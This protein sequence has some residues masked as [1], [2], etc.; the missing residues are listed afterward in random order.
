MHT[1]CTDKHNA[2]IVH[3]LFQATN[4][5]Y[6]LGTRLASSLIWS[7]LLT[8]QECMKETYSKYLHQ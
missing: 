3:V 5:A 6:D 4:A 8:C 2:Q 1:V 7:S